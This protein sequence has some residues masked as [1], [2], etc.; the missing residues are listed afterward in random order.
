MP[1]RRTQRSHRARGDDALQA[2]ILE[3]L[4]HEMRTPLCTILGLV[5]L[6]I[7]TPGND[8][9]RAE[10]L[11]DIA[12]AGERLNRLLDDGLAAAGDAHATWSIQ[13]ARVDLADVL[14]RA[15]RE[16]GGADR[17]HLEVAVALPLVR[18]DA[19][20][21]MQIAVNLLE[22][23]LRYAPRGSAVRLTAEAGDGCVCVR[24]SDLGP[25]LPDAAR[26]FEVFERGEGALGLHPSG[27]GF[28]LYVA[29]ALVEAQGGCIG[30]EPGPGCT[31]AWTLPVWRDD[32][33]P[34]RGVA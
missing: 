22:N 18:A 25:G 29:K 20:R 28:G 14:H 1:S 17:V 7:E 11:R 27:R 16:S 13:L 32:A 10:M 34:E 15:V 30:A 6:L 9:E 33:A 31:I 24:V 4:A 21:V 12:S 23:A 26:C 2:R 8:R 3:F 19:D 5:D